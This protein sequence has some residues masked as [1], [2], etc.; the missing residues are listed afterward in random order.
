MDESA[1]ARILA[2]IA[3]KPVVKSGTSPPASPHQPGTASPPVPASTDSPVARVIEVQAPSSPPHSTAPPPLSLGDALSPQ[4]GFMSP[5]NRG[6]S[7]AILSSPKRGHGGDK[8]SAE[9]APGSADRQQ[10]I[11][12][13]GPVSKIDGA[14][15]PNK[16]YHVAQT[17]KNLQWVD[18]VNFKILS[19]NGLVEEWAEQVNSIKEQTIKDE[20]RKH[21]FIRN[22]KLEKE[23]DVVDG[24]IWF[25][26]D[27]LFRRGH[28]EYLEQIKRKYRPKRVKSTETASTASQGVQTSDPSSWQA[29]QPLL[30]AMQPADAPDAPPPD[31]G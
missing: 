21:N 23:M 26:R 13:R 4:P 9:R 22:R 10:A 15:F 11:R 1:A 8:S 27:S 24:E 19:Y 6:A 7:L 16:L 3:Q 12:K 17:S 2:D 29:P 20:L 31:L 18:D 5:M 14:Y 30:L 25:H 28:E